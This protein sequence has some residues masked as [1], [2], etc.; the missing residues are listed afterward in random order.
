MIGESGPVQLIPPGLLG[1]MQ[2]KNEGRN[3]RTFIESYQPVIE[4]RQW[5]MQQNWNETTD[6]AAAL[7]AGITGVVT[8]PALISSGQSWLY[9]HEFSAYSTVGG[10]GIIRGKCIFQRITGGATPR[11]FAGM[12]VEG[13]S[14]TAT[15]IC[16]PISS[17]FFMPPNMQLGVFVSENTLAGATTFTANLRWTSLPI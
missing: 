12:Q 3:P 17:G 9:I 5:M 8:F 10:A 11:H 13:L 4:M 2:L 6:V 14:T 16:N 7:A 1:M 15:G